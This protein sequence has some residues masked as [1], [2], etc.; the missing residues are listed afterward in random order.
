MFRGLSAQDNLACAGRTQLIRRGAGGRV[1]S[2]VNV[3]WRRPGQ[4]RCHPDDYMNKTLLVLS[5]VFIAG[6]AFWIG[7]YS[8]TPGD[9]DEAEFIE[10][11][12]LDE[13]SFF[14]EEY[15]DHFD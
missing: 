9:Q 7:R 11:N 12:T 15:K 8:A 2:E 14:P 13:D 10:R 6:M 4:R 3:D 1:V 5:A